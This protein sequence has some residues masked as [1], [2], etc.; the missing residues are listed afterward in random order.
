[1]YHSKRS[2]EC[3]EKNES[4]FNA[5]NPTLVSKSGVGGFRGKSY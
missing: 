5:K 2:G 1:M 4:I 3:R